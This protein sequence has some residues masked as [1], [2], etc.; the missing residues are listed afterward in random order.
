MGHHYQVQFGLRNLPCVK[1][2]TMA[3]RF[4]PSNRH[5]PHECGAPG[6]SSLALLAFRG[7]YGNRPAHWPG[8]AET[9]NRNFT[10]PGRTT[11]GYSQ[12]HGLVVLCG[13][14][15]IAIGRD[16][17]PQTPHRAILVECHPGLCRWHFA[18]LANDTKLVV[19]R[20]AQQSSSNMPSL[21]LPGTAQCI[22]GMTGCQLDSVAAQTVAPARMAGIITAF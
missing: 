7:S 17:P 18:G 5:H 16:A 13:N 4:P 12:L 2:G 3:G 8:S 19:A 22:S 14:R 10:V 9:D 21:A 1:A 20:P 15:R 11:P 6:Y